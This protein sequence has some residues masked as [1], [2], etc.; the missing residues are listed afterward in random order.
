M[1]NS[2]KMQ[3]TSTSA[4]ASPSAVPEHEASNFMLRC[5]CGNTTATATNAWGCFC[6]HCRQCPE[7]DKLEDWAGGAPWVAVP[8]IQEWNSAKQIQ[9]QR[10]SSFAER[11]AC[12]VCGHALYIQY[13]C[14]LQTSW[15]HAGCFESQQIPASRIWHIHCGDEFDLGGG[16]RCFRGFEPWEADPCRPAGTAE[17]LVCRRCFQLTCTCESS[18]AGEVGEVPLTGVGA[19]S[20]DT[21]SAKEESEREDHHLSEVHITAA[22]LD[23]ASATNTTSTQFFYSMATE[24]E[25]ENSEANDEASWGGADDEGDLVLVRRPRK[26]QRLRMRCLTLRHSLATPL[27]TVGLQVWRGAL[28]LS[29]WLLANRTLVRGA[30]VLDLGAGTGLTSLVA[31][32]AGARTVFCTD[33]D[34]EVLANAA[35]NAAEHPVPG[36]DVR[37]R[38]LDWAS[39]AFS[40]RQQWGHHAAGT[41]GNGAGGVYGWTAEDAVE[42]SRGSL[43]LAADCVYSDD[44][45]DALLG[46]VERLLRER[47]APGAVALFA[48]ERRVNFCLEGL[49]SRAPAAEHFACVTC[50]R[51]RTL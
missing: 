13:D 26:R 39:D 20:E 15:V 38:Q 1:N 46:C 33:H 36:S 30:A 5:P 12:G 21:S 11:G 4:D 50:V 44:A 35:A 8:R 41:G 25:D 45:T 32:A 49:C 23:E 6:C 48:S 18:G 14:E 17:P 2:K 3:Q 16:R 40:P 47:L 22:V 29:D 9:K 28:L 51:A 24:E 37:L 7:K 34:G 42:L 43:I 27:R 31:A 19:S 10:S